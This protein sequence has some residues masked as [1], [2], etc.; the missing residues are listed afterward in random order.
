MEYNPVA[1]IFFSVLEFYNLEMGTFFTLI[2][3]ISLAFHEV[4]EIS[5][6][7]MGK[8]RYEE[9]IPTK[10]ELH[11]LRAR[12]ALAYDTYWELLCHYHICVQTI[13]L[14]NYGVK[15]RS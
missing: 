11:L 12:D 15:Q 14:R 6:L 8:I 7:P 10:G 3:E 4:Y 1:S 13:G 2:G 5:G 9:Y